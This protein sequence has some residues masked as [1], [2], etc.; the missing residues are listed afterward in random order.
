M[1]SATVSGRLGTDA[2]RTIAVA[3]ELERAVKEYEA[4][5]SRYAVA[6]VNFHQLPAFGRDAEE[7][8]RE[9]AIEHMNTCAKLL[10]DIV[11]AAMKGQ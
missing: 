5:V 11:A 1:I 6:A 2:Q 10:A 7:R 9:D 3:P 8:E 4:A